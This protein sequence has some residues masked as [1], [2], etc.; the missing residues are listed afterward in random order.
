MKQLN[1][2]LTMILMLCMVASK[3]QNKENPW[4]L[5]LGAQGANMTIGDNTKNYYK[6]WHVF[7]APSQLKLFRY[8]GSGFS[9][10][11][12]ISLGTARR[13][14][15]LESQFFL[16]WGIDLKYSF[17]NGYI[18]KDK[19]WFDPY[20]LLGGGLN[21]F[22]DVRG[23]INFGAGL[24]IWFVKNFGGFI[25][26]QYNYMPH[27]KITPHVNDARPSFMLH[28]MGIVVRF[29]KGKD[30]DKDGIPDDQDKCP[31]DPGKPEFDG[32]PDTDGDGIIDKD[33]KCPTVPG[34]AAF[35][36]CPDTDGDGI[37]DADDACPTQPGPAATK[38]CPDQDGDGIAD[39]DDACPT[40]PGPA[41]TQGCPDR[42]GDGIADKDDACPDQKGPAA[43]KGC[44]DADGDGIPDK[45]DKC[46]SVFGIAENQGCPKP[47]LDETKKAEVQKKLSFAAKN[48]FFESG[49]DVLKKESSKQLDSVVAIL[50]QYDFLRVAIDGHT[51]NVGSEKSNVELSNLRAG[52]V[53]KYLTDHGVAASRLTASGYGPYKP[54]ADNKTAAGRAQ[55]RRVEINIKD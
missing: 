50:T 11:T 53:M 10:G 36:G 8:V 41:A 38:G 43:T 2:L 6:S 46:P 30:T 12:Q 32:C 31:T 9:L 52:A 26:S 28:S 51:D 39:K 29:G 7:P 4:L 14:D 23:S 1:K 3:A 49:K 37:Q 19:S 44:P 18:L 45:D 24:S 17:A 34:I 5:G 55:N 22:G 16:Q 13:F 21:K 25:Q 27:D 48:I 42:D 20:F 40:Q 54:I 35:Q 15:S 33:D 47:A